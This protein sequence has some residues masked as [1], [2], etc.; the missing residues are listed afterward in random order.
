MISNTSVLRS[1][2]YKILQHG[3]MTNEYFKYTKNGPDVMCTFCTEEIE[4][5]PHL[6]YYCSIVN[7]FMDEAYQIIQEMVPHVDSYVN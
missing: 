3:L 4:T 5:I 1:L 7:E 2:Q 6:F